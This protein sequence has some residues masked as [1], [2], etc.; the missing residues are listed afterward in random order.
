VSHIPCEHVQSAAGKGATIRG[1]SEH[2]ISTC[3]TTHVPSLE[4]PEIEY[5]GLAP[6]KKFATLKLRAAVIG[7]VAMDVQSSGET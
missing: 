7:S 4:I 1:F 5:G 2:I 6:H 3:L